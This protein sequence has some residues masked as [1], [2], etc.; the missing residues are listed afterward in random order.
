MFLLHDIMDTVSVIVVPSHPSCARLYP[1]QVLMQVL[2]SCQHPH[3][4][5]SWITRNEGYCA[6]ISVSIAQDVDSSC[7][8]A[9]DPSGSVEIHFT[10]YTFSLNRAPPRNDLGLS[11]STSCSDTRLHPMLHRRCQGFASAA[12]N[13][14]GSA[15]SISH[16]VLLVC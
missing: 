12:S 16:C 7:A 3:W 15:V 13:I 5:R 11:Y 6:S 2:F 10:E 8:H 1:I 9:S 4:P 14:L